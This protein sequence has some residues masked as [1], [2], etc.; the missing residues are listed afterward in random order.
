D[1]FDPLLLTTHGIG[2][3]K[4]KL[5][6]ATYEITLNT[7]DFGGQHIYHATHQFFL[8]KR[9]LY[10]VVWN[11]RLGVGQ[12]RLDYW[13]DT[14]KTLAPNAPVI[15]VATHIDERSPDLNYQLYKDTYPQ[16]VGSIS[17]S[18]LNGMGIAELKQ[19]LT[20]QAL[21]LPLVGQLWPKKWLAVEELLAA[22]PEQHIDTVTYL[23]YC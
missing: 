9:S 23:H 19:A 12:G 3:S 22:R 21:K 7:W 4:L 5:P 13:L 2:I 6:H 15:L 1:T 16:L 18:N 17:I 20:K 10:I 8:T 14:I 11:A